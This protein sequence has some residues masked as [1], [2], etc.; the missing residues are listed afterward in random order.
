VKVTSQSSD[1]AITGLTAG[2]LRLRAR[3]ESQGEIASR[4]GVD[5]SLVSRYA[6]G[7]AKPPKAQ[8][9]ILAKEFGIP[10][11]L[12]DEDPRPPTE[13]DWSKVPPLSRESFEANTLAI[14]ADVT[15]VRAKAK[16]YEAA[17]DTKT[18]LRIIKETTA[19]QALLGK[20]LGTTLEI[21]EER[22][23]RLPAVRRI[24]TKIAEALRPYPDAYRA[25]FAISKTVDSTDQGDASRDV[26]AAGAHT[27]D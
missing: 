24:V 22:A 9:R 21:P 8:R 27:S 13:P 6:T 2:A 7:K 1:P 14:Y 17:G 20:L 19:A 15:R 4:L 25:V 16:A 18:Y 3:S 12:W 11:A 23:M 5:R 10:V 26:P